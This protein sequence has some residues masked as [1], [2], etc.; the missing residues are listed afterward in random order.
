[1]VDDEVMGKVIQLQGDQRTKILSMLVEEGISEFFS[2]FMLFL[3]GK[4]EIGLEWN[5]MEC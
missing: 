4:G 5:R 1:M 2:F 3:R